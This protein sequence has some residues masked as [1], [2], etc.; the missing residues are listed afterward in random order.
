MKNTIAP[1]L[2]SRKEIPEDL[3]AEN[4]QILLLPMGCETLQDSNYEPYL[5]CPLPESAICLSTERRG[6]VAISTGC[7]TVVMLK[8]GADLLLFTPGARN[9]VPDAARG[10]LQHAFYNLGGARNQRCGIDF[11]EWL[12]SNRPTRLVA[13]MQYFF[14]TPSDWLIGFSTETASKHLFSEPPIHADDDRVNQWHQ[15]D[16]LQLRSPRPQLEFYCQNLQ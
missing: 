7:S 2:R 10:V 6:K 3:I 4:A 13:V 15:L 5:D 11:V 9:Q 16:H 1:L 14:R 12:Y 8:G